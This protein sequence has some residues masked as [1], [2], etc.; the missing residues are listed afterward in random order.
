[1][2]LFFSF[3]VKA[4]ALNDADFNLKVSAAFLGNLSS[5]DLPNITEALKKTLRDFGYVI[6]SAEIMDTKHGMSGKNR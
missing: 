2:V 6:E 3:S 5:A 1:M 4:E